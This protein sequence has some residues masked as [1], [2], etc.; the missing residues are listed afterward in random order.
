MIGVSGLALLGLSA[1]G[2]TNI[3][4]LEETPTYGSKALYAFNV[5]TNK[6]QVEKITDWYL[7]PP[8]EEDRK[9]CINCKTNQNPNTYSALIFNN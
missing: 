4:S 6:G 5:K 1:C 9:E 8:E 7:K 3:S 2:S